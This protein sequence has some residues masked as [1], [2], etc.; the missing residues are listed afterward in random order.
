MATETHFGVRLPVAGPLATPA[1]IVRAAREADGLGFETVW[2]HDYICWN[3][4]L[5]SAH[6]SCGSK[7][8]FLAAVE[9]PN[10]EPRFFE[11]ITNLAFLAGITERVRLGVAV[12]IL[13]YREALVTAKQL[14]CVDVLSG[15]RLDLGIGQGAAKSTF[16]T[17]N[18]VMGVSRATKVRHT[19]EVFEAMREVWS[20]TPAS[21]HGRF[22]DFTDAEVYPKP[23]QRPC[24]RTWMGGSADKS[25]EMVADYADAWLSCWVSPEQFPQA[26]GE[27]RRKLE[28]RGRDWSTFIGG[29]EVQIYLASSP[30]VARK[31]VEATMLAFEEGYAGTTGGFADEGKR[32]DALQEIWKSSLIG[33]AASVSEEIT[34]YL[35]AGC[36]AFELKFIY[37][38]IDQ[39]IEQ[40]HMFTE[41]VLPNV[42]SL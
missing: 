41:E 27:L 33:S 31:E 32:A 5:D 30:E 35:S 21:Y 34:R 28:A 25:L 26:L 1:G 29:T 14:A 38:S 15:G 7:E 9:G 39:L 11:S 2:V 42:A 36:T 13:P 22:V 18:E 8:A 24:P 6:I 19:R 4:Q 16:N 10:Y 12:L 40:W 23:I 37:S 20:Q 3:R 17:E